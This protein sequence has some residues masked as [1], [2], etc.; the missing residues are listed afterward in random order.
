MKQ[1]PLFL[2]LWLFALAL[3]HAHAAATLQI[4][5]DKAVFLAATGA[6]NATGPL[7]NLGAISSGSATVGSVTF[8]GGDGFYIG[9]AGEPTV[10][11]DWYPPTPGNDMALGFE[12]LLVQPATPVF[13]LGFEIVE[14]NLTV[15]PWGGVPVDSTYEVTLFAG[16]N[17][18]GQFTFNVPDDVVAFVGVWS[19]IAFDQVQILDITASPNVDDDEYF[20]EFYTGTI[21]APSQTF[22]EVTTCGQT[23]NAPGEYVLAGDLD[24]SGTHDHG[25]AITA[26]NVVVHLAG[27]TLASTDCQPDL[28]ISGIVVAQ[29]LS[30]VEI[31]GGTI[32]GFNAG[33][34]LLASASL[35]QAM[36][37]TDA[38]VVGMQVAGGTGNSIRDN[39]LRSNFDGIQ[40]QASD[41][42][43]DGN[44]VTDHAVGIA[45][46][47]AGATNQIRANT[48]TGNSVDLADDNDACGTNTWDNNIFETDAVAGVSDGGPAEGCIR[49][50]L[51]LACPDATLCVGENQL[52]FLA[53][54][55]GVDATGPL[56]AAGEIKKS[57]TVER[58]TFTGKKMVVTDLT[59]LLAGNELALTGTKKAL[60][61]ALDRLVWGAGFAYVQ[62]TTGGSG[63]SDTTLTVKLM[64]GKKS[65]GEFAFKAA[66][67]AAAF[68]GVSSPV[69]F[70]GMQ[71]RD[72]HTAGDKLLLF[73]R[74]WYSTRALLRPYEIVVVFGNLHATGGALVAVD[75]GTGTRRVV[76][77]FGNVKQGPLGK[78]PWS[79]I[80][81]SNTIFVVDSL[82]G[83]NS[84]ALFRVDEAGFRTVVSDFGN[85]A[86]GPIGRVP[87]R[88]VL[89]HSGQL[90]VLD[91][92]SGTAGRGALFRVDPESGQRSLV[93]DFG[94]SSQGPLADDLSDVAVDATG[95]ILVAAFLG[96][97]NNKGAI[98][99]VDPQKGKRTI[100]SDFGKTVQGVSLDGSRSIAVDETGQILV[101]GRDLEGIGALVRVDPKTG[102]RTLVSDF[103]NI[104]QGPGGLNPS[105]IAVDAAGTVYV[106]DRVGLSVALVQVDPV[107]GERTGAHVLDF[108]NSE[109]QDMV[110]FTVPF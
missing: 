78:F 63:S 42:V 32:R 70:D 19:D 89:E 109:A 90:L 50:A 68:V 51:P 2:V 9:A 73:G 95:Q 27:H 67:D 41:T 74:V 20:G 11:P 60:D 7:P 64:S 87:G 62:P 72:H 31:E 48:A 100:L 13:A 59:P 18:I 61:V 86:Q 55:A 76:S 15:Q 45:I 10:E 30:G 102:F 69:P 54:T 47:E 65:V 5:D 88:G 38:C 83:T 77:D 99:R 40:L 24:C 98:F 52:A 39:T 53:A 36:T 57:L 105:Y 16:L 23:L 29:G 108:P 33:I 94:K 91:D 107:S 97:T 82:A 49:G 3:S 96:G 75:P 80:V 101:L 110:L 46:S 79:A 17:Q 25:V 92:S 58:V 1:T 21:P 4:F 37:L 44:T 14:P 104:L 34:A 22:T 56:P 28:P 93:T 43:V 84:G 26:S 106:L 103:G 85:P 8:T 71:I 6:V 35:V 12:N 81:S 66:N